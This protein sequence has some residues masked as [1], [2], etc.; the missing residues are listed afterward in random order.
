MQAIDTLLLRLAGKEPLHVQ[1]YGALRDR[2]LSGELPRGARLPSSRQ[3][4]SQLGVARS[5]VLQAID[6]LQAEGYLITRAASSTRVAPELPEPLARPKPAGAPRQL[7]PPR[8]SQAAKALSQQPRAVSRLGPSPRA[9]HPGIPALDLFPG[10]LWARFV[11][12]EAVR[13]SAGLFSGGDPAGHRALREA[14]A[15]H[16]TTARGVRCSWEQVF[17]TAGT[18]GAFHETAR[19]V[20]DPGEEAWL[21]DPAYLGARGALILAGAR[22]APVPVDE[23]GMDVEAGI[24]R[25]PNARL[26]LLAPSHQYPLGVTL[27]LPR[28]LALLRWAAQTRA[29][30]VE[31]DYDSEFR[32]RGRPLMAM[33]G[34]DENGVVAYVGTFSKTMFPGLRIGFVV[35]PPTMVDAFAAARALVPAPASSI[36]QAA[37][38]RFI[39]EGHFATHLRRMRAV[40]RERGEALVEGLLRQCTGALHPNPPETGMQLFAD[41]EESLSDTRVRDEC[42]ARG[43]EVGSVSD[44]FLGRTT[45][46]GLVLGF[47]CARVASIRAAVEKLAQALEAAQRSPR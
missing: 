7:R 19:L 16:I 30:I 32:H 23:R 18:Q 26:V 41:L 34:L 25:Y 33:Q 47:G 46:S 11:A 2:I 38:A 1:I 13:A 9:F 15:L 40:Y 4:A 6:A 24:A 14:I 10:P 3:L 5:T 45:H 31:D 20:L 27:S 12:R 37:L 21:E 44:R 22:I 8:L 39:S 17:I 35:A 43:V 29:V 28:R 36:D 42:A